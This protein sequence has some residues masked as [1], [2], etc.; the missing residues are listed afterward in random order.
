MFQSFWTDRCEGKKKGCGR[1]PVLCLIL[2]TFTMCSEKK[3][4]GESHQDGS[5]SPYRHDF[6]IGCI[7]LPVTLDK[8]WYDYYSWERPVPSI[9]INSYTKQN[10]PNFLNTCCGLSSYKSLRI[11]FDL[12]GVEHLQH[13][14]LPSSFRLPVAQWTPCESQGPYSLLCLPFTDGRIPRSHHTGPPFMICCL[15]QPS[16]QCNHQAVRLSQNR[17][18]QSPC[19]RHVPRVP[20]NV[21]DQK[22]RTVLGSTGGNMVRNQTARSS[23]SGCDRT[24]QT[25]R[26]AKTKHKGGTSF[27]VECTNHHLGAQHVMT[28]IDW[29]WPKVDCA[30]STLPF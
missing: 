29:C 11:H 5:S 23:S 25:C 7:P 22:T 12:L 30:I 3:N 13:C 19:A 2:G 1:C 6:L 27:F 15:Q 28:M 4:H 20:S 16:I 18:S 10:I 9:I 17:S 8:I 21:G 26:S 24:A 14:D